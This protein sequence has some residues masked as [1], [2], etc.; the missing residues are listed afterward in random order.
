MSIDR[1]YPPT[2][3]GVPPDLTR[4]DGSYRLQVAAMIAGLFGFLALYLLLVT[5]AG[6]LAY[7]LVALPLPREG[8]RGL[9][10]ILLVKIGG[11]L[12]AGLLCVFLFKGLF[13][14]QRGGQPADTPLREEDHPELFAFIRRVYTDAGAPPPARVFVSP[15]VNAALVF[16]SSLLSLFLPPRK[17]LLIGLGLVNVVTLAEFKAVLAHEFGHFA[18]SSV[19]LGSYLHVANRVMTDIV[20]SRDALDRFVDGWASLDI[21]VSFPAWG[22]KGVLWVVRKLLG[23]V[24]QGLNLLHLSLSRQLEYNADNV[25]VSLAGSDAIIHGLYRLE[26]ASECLADAANSLDAAADH[27][28]FSDDLFYHQA[29]AA[30][31]LRRREGAARAGLPPDLPTDPTEQVRVFEPKYDGIPDHYRSHPT[32]EMRERNAK[33]RYIRSPLDD[34]S[35]W[36]LFG[37]AVELRR[38]VT[39][40]I[41]RHNLGRTEPFTQSPAAEV[42]AFIDAEHAESTYDARYH[43]LFDDRFIEPGD[44]A[45]VSRIAP[46]SPAEVTAWL[47]DWPPADVK[48]RMTTFREHQN[49]FN[50]LRG[51][52]TG[53]LSLKG[54]S[55]PFRGQQRTLRDLDGLLTEVDAEIS[56][57]AKS[58][59]DLDRA[60]LQIHGSAARH[61]DAIDG[62]NRATDLSARY[63]FHMAVQGLLKKMLDAQ[64]RLQG[65][66]AAL[67]GVQQ[68][69]PEDFARARHVLDDVHVDL[70]DVLR[71]ARPLRTPAMANVAAGSSLFELIS[72]RAD[73]ELER[74]AGDSISGAWIGRLAVRVEG[75]LGRVKRVHFK[76]LGGLLAAQERLQADWRACTT[77]NEGTEARAQGER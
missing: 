71:D 27:G 41:Y 17:D 22:L 7:W 33:R 24:L 76:S 50:I 26:F 32:H 31:R 13:K 23:G 39:A 64:G 77:E 52:K 34:R 14:G 43:G 61:L 44:V 29:R 70:R 63:E 54:K 48:E 2:P 68:L 60:A 73:G 18:Q 19:G 9:G 36:L 57:A 47:A 65:M 59:H 49:A 1:L 20:Y 30:E 11:A 72:D 25:A 12:A 58:F 62:G 53:E 51:L 46:R 16:D 38:E 69:S 3:A 35:P 4:P 45:D 8:G 21:R 42:Q 28:L 66:M 5:A 74:L 75:V 40:R 6:L 56:A 67:T 10:G 15:D 55:F 37:K